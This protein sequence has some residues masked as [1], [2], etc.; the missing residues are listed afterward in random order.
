[1]AITV[2]ITGGIGS[3]KSTICAVFKLLGAPVFEADVV[4]KQLINTNSEIKTGG[5]PSNGFSG[6]RK[7]QTIKTR[8]SV[9]ANREQKI[10]C[11]THRQQR[12]VSP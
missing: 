3:G 7:R 1:M 9:H 12:G 11:L 2:G 8:R 6:L 5:K 4:A 10:K